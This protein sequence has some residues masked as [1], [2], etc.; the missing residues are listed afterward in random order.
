MKLSEND[1]NLYNEYFVNFLTNVLKYWKRIEVRE[2]GKKYNV[3]DV[4]KG[5]NRISY[6]ISV[7]QSGEE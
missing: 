2:G 7:M 5:L 4:L 3:F 6:Y 1:N